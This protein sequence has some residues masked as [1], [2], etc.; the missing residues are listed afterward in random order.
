V[1]SLASRLSSRL[2]R[3]PRKRSPMMKRRK[4]RRRRT[5]AKLRKRR[6]R[7]KRRRSRKYQ[8]TL[9]RWTRISHFGWEKL[10]TSRRKSTLTSTSS[11]PMTGKS[12]FMWN[13]SQLKEV[14]SS[15]LSS[16]SQREPHLI[17]SKPKRRR[18]TSSFMSEGSLSW[19]IVMSSSLNTWV[20]WKELLTQK[21]CLLTSRESSSSIIRSLRLSRRTS[22]R[23]ALKWFRKYV[24]T[25]KTT[26]NFTSSSPRTSSSESTRTLL[27][28]LNSL[29][30]WDSTPAKVETNKSLSRTILA[31]WRKVRTIFSSSLER[32]RAQLLNPHSSN[33]WR[34]KVL[35][36]STWLT[37]LMSMWS[38][39]SKN[40][41]ERS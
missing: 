31:E 27:T 12:I 26:R 4:K 38:S 19:T 5:R 34:R 13:N 37:P 22:P 18:I 21:I 24:K 20:S 6:R 39:N 15:R 25:L 35:K 9:S 2:K 36:F 10:K 41:K 16:S 8:L 29:T 1:S 3:R 11:S 7:N 40:M 14:L 23:S 32:T 33:L 30:S 28:E 17:F